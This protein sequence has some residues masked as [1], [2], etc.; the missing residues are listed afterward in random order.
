M[1][2]ESSIMNEST[3]QGYRV[4]ILS[5]CTPGLACCVDNNTV[6]NPG[7]FR[8]EA[9]MARN[10]ARA[11][12]M[13]ALYQEG[14]SQKQVGEVFGCAPQVVAKMFQRRHWPMRKLTY[15]R[16]GRIVGHH[17]YIMVRIGTGHHLSNG[18]GYGYEHRV[19]AEKTLGRDLMPHEIVHHIDHCHSNNDPANLL[20]VQSDAEHK[21]LH[22]AP[23]QLILCACGCGTELWERNQ[24]GKKRRY[25]MGHFKRPKHPK[26]TREKT[27]LIR[28]YTYLTCPQCGIDFRVKPSHA[29][30]KTYC[31]IACMAEAYK[32]RQRGAN[33]PN[34][35][36]G[37]YV[38]AKEVLT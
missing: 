11:E 14:K 37:K 3:Q 9:D 34:W 35:R 18:S 32:E 21:A 8:L 36:H 30:K 4:Q 17:G 29:S 7:V 26:K 13:Y 1:D 5:S 25:L 15:T 16:P 23:N 27:T 20:V 2:A 33:N 24:H 28:V 19:V 6:F 22:C 12:A 10:D 38:E 31:C